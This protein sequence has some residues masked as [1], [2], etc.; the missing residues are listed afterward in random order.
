MTKKAIAEAEKPSAIMTFR[1]AIGPKMKV[2]GAPST[3]SSGI[4]VLSIRSMPTG[5][6]SQVLA[7][8]LMP[9]TMAQGVWA[10]NHTSSPVSLPPVACSVWANP[11]TQTFLFA[12]NATKTYATRLKIVPCQRKNRD[13]PPRGRAWRP[14]RRG[15]SLPAL[16]T[17]R[18]RVPVRVRESP[19]G[20]G[21]GC[22]V[23]PAHGTT[24]H[25]PVRIGVGIRRTLPVA[26]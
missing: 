23:P 5:A 2:I 25:V 15:A 21:A 17:L 1:V 18:G 3:P 24:T 14:R 20:S 6:L 12:R 19:P 8:G 9:C 22:S 26:P 10:R 13:V 16:S 11:W 4:V 7:N